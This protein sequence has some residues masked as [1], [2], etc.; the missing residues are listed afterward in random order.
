[1]WEDQVPRINQCRNIIQLMIYLSGGFIN[2]YR[3]FQHSDYNNQGPN[4]ALSIT[5][6]IYFKYLVEVQ[7]MVIE[8]CVYLNTPS[9]ES[10]M[11]LNKCMQTKRLKRE[12]NYSP[13][14]LLWKESQCLKNLLDIDRSS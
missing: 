12:M 9:A 1:M 5:S 2:Y 10:E 4:T 13:D 3:W 6:S 11:N 8:C 7:S 14:P